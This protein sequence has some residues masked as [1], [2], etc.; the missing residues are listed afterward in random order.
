MNNIFPLWENGSNRHACEVIMIYTHA[1]QEW[2][3]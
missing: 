1:P 2:V 3:H